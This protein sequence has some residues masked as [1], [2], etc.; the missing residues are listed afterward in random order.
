[1]LNKYGIFLFALAAMATAAPV[2]AADKLVP[3]LIGH[4]APTPPDFVSLPQWSVATVPIGADFGYAD[5]LKTLPFGVAFRDGGRTFDARP[6]MSWRF[7]GYYEAARDG[8]VDFRAATDARVDFV[9]I[10]ANEGWIDA[11]EHAY[12]RCR[13]IFELGGRPVINS[14][15]GG[16][17]NGKTSEIFPERTGKAAV[18]AGLNPV[19]G[20]VT[21]YDVR[22]LSGQR[23]PTETGIYPQPAEMLGWTNDKFYRRGALQDGRRRIRFSANDGSGWSDAG[24]KRRD[25]EKL[26]AFDGAPVDLMLQP[27]VL[28][29]GVAAGWDAEYTVERCVTS[30]DCATLARSAGVGDQRGTETTVKSLSEGH[31]DLGQ[32]LVEELKRSDLGVKRSAA[33]LAPL[34]GPALEAK[35]TMRASALFLPQHAGSHVFGVW[36]SDD[37]ALLDNGV[38]SHSPNPSDVSRDVAPCSMTLA[39]D[40][41][42]INIPAFEAIRAGIRRAAIFFEVKLEKKP[43][44]AEITSSCML[45][46]YDLNRDSRL[47]QADIVVKSPEMMAFGHPVNS[48][49]SSRAPVKPGVFGE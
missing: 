47:P 48:L 22:M 1:M 37:P 26:L 30:Q 18:K 29:P 46:R 3:G 23:D 7:E 8:V 27:N 36:V 21:C 9:Q 25:D 24:F 41:K 15:V 49:V 34:M 43:V 16:S 17:V 45:R 13:V 39:I 10:G 5:Y 32:S 40:G 42:S 19:G 20:V 35:I 44:K 31:I 33:L 12:P 38:V 6:P 14:F 2:S 11:L 4:V 28:R